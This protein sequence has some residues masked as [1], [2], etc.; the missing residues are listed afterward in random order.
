[1]GGASFTPKRTTDLVDMP[2]SL[3]GQSGKIPVI[4]TSET[5]FRFAKPD[6]DL[7]AV[8]TIT[9]TGATAQQTNYPISL[10]VN[11]GSGTSAGSTLYCGSL[12]QTDFSDI[13]FSDGDGT[14]L[15]FWIVNYVAGDYADII[16]SLPTIPASP[17]TVDF[18]MWYGVVTTEDDLRI[19]ICG[20]VHYTST[21]YSGYGT[22]SLTYLASFITR[23]ATFSPHLTGLMGDMVSAGNNTDLTNDETAVRNAYDNMGGARFVVPGNH[24]FDYMT[25]AQWLA[26][27][28]EFCHY[29]QP[30]KAYGS[31]DVGGYHFV[32]LDGNYNSTTPYAHIST[33]TYPSTWHIPDGTDGSHD[34][35]GWLRADLAR[36]NKPTIVFCH[37]GL[38]DLGT[39]WWVLTDAIGVVGNKAAVQAILEDSGKV[40]A[41]FGG[42]IHCN[43]WKVVNGIPYIHNTVFNFGPGT[44]IVGIREYPATGTEK[45]AWTEVTINKALGTL[46]CEFYEDDSVAGVR[47]SVE[48]FKFCSDVGA[49]KPQNPYNAFVDFDGDDIANWS[50]PTPLFT[51]IEVRHSRASETLQGI[52]VIG[53]NTATVSN[54][55]RSLT[56]QNAKFKMFFTA[57]KEETNKECSIQIYNTSGGTTG[58]YII[59]DASGNIQ[60]HN[61]TSATT[62]RSYS[63]NTAYE[64]ELT[65]DVASHTFD[66]NIDEVSEGTGLA[67]YNATM[68]SLD[69]LKIYKPASQDFVFHIDKIRVQKYVSP[70]PGVS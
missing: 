59:F 15:P 5:S 49:K 55:Y 3:T 50:A 24:D 42:H 39:G 25:L 4:A 54:A 12:C 52:K 27:W 17:S 20:D 58:P 64:F 41:V 47:K 32:V 13:R 23:M 35:L 7:W 14:F 26:V 60:Y 16:V 21:G 62:L 37:A 45:S 34:Q 18:E 33:T 67:F 69:A 22:S 36:T 70:E 1:M 8:Q 9:V 66:I 31:F 44:G 46:T 48:A 11:Y 38:A 30:N 43:R 19:G 57:G 56:S 40:I 6:S 65:V 61:G 10:T 63:A 68:G 28:G 29:Y 53:K 51:H 2:S